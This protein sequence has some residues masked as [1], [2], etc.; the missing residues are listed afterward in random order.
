MSIQKSRNSSIDILRIVAMVAIVISHVTQSLQ[1]PEESYSTTNL[2]YCI[3]FVRASSDM[4]MWGLVLLRMLGVWGNTVFII[5]SAWF[6]CKD[7]TVKSSKVIR[8][9]LDTFTLSVLILAAFL[10]LG[11]HTW[12]L[13]WKT[14][15][16]CL[17]PTTFANNWFVTCYLMLYIMHPAINWTVVKLGQRNHA[18][19]TITL[20]V[21]YMLI[22]M[23]VSGLFFWTELVFML[24]VYVLVSYVRTY[25]KDFG[26][27]CFDKLLLYRIIVIGIFGTILSVILLEDAGQRIEF[28]SGEMLH[29]D[30][31]GNPF[32]VLASLGLV[33]LA[34]NHHFSS[35]LITRIS[36]YM[37]F[38]YL[39]HENLLVR[40]YLRPWI[41]SQIHALYG[42]HYLYLLILVFSLL[43]FLSSLGFSALYTCTISRFFQNHEKQLSDVFKSISTHIVNLFLNTN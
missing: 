10:L 19:L 27:S 31:D 35:N 22:P 21:L 20:V 14:I 34:I 32:I 36:G 6:M 11:N 24:S 12:K 18:C 41:W 5:I 29:F 33:G 15:L 28:L 40:T 16:K 2:S 42:Y 37:L 13:G 30:F 9:V 39:I 17:F 38:V 1:I 25:L 8:L 3:D 7:D 26:K 23:I 43:L 4:K